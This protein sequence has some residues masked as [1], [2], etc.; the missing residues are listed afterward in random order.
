M[1]Q[2]GIITLARRPSLSR[3]SQVQAAKTSTQQPESL[4]DTG[5]MHIIVNK[6]QEETA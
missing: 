1:A 2:Q 3:R 4:E 5:D 6:T